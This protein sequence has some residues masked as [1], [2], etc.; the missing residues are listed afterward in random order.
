MET[1]TEG[2]WRE[3]AKR[4]N[5]RVIVEDSQGGIKG[6]EVWYPKGSGQVPSKGECPQG[7]GTSS[8]ECSGCKRDYKT[9]LFPQS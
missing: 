3:R 2:I 5:T 1:V 7:H 6:M 4:N 8:G 9:T